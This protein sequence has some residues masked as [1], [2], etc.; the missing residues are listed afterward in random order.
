MQRIQ[1]KNELDMKNI[2][3]FKAL[4]KLQRGI[5]NNQVQGLTEQVQEEENQ[6]QE[7][8]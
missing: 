2:D 8:D 1:K 3:D 5:T 4:E 7:N 6:R